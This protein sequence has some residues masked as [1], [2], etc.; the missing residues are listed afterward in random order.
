M[1]FFFG[2]PALLGQYSFVKNTTGKDWLSLAEICSETDD[3]YHIS[4]KVCYGSLL[5][6]KSSG[7][8]TVSARK[9][10]MC[11]ETSRVSPIKNHKNTQ[12]RYMQYVAGNFF[13]SS[14]YRE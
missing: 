14:Y 8:D 7:P 12:K 10:I 5:A 9:S 11:V 4:Q 1:H 2:L 3:L 6:D 13:C